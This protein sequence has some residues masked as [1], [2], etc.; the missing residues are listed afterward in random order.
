MHFARLKAYT[1]QFEKLVLDHLKPYLSELAEK[2]ARERRVRTRDSVL[3]A[4]C[5]HYLGK[6]EIVSD[7]LRGDADLRASAVAHVAQGLAAHI[8][9]VWLDMVLELADVVMEVRLSDFDERMLLP[10]GEEKLWYDYLSLVTTFDESE[11]LPKRDQL[12][13]LF[14]RIRSSLPQ[15]EPI[16]R[17][18]R[19]H[20]EAGCVTFVP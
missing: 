12:L 11:A 2:E 13:E 15:G 8:A 5:N 18:A 10:G 19:L 9:T 4:L 1:A 7:D 17:S 6:P 3:E 14:R 16:P 20:L